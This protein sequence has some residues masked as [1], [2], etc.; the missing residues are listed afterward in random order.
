MKLQRKLLFLL[1]CLIAST[2]LKAQI[3]L[4][5]LSFKGYSALGFG[6]FFNFA[7]PVSDANY[8]TGEIGLDV[9]SSNGEN[10]ALAPL[11]LGYRYTLDGSGTGFYVEPNAGYSF[12]GTDIQMTDESGNY[13]YQKVSGASAGLTAG[14]LFQPSGR[15]QF[16]LGVRYEHTFFENGGSNM[17]SFRISHAFTFGK[18]E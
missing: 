13:T 16:N 4:D 8:V 6:G 9:F 2:S 10:V 14:Y 15:I 18:R 11:L 12:A 17:F 7:V 3:Q 5:H 1:F